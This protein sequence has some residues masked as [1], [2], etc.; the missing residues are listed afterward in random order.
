MWCT[1]PTA[2]LP[3]SLRRASFKDFNREQGV[4][5]SELYD[6]NNIAITDYESSLK[7]DARL[8]RESKGTPRT[9]NIYGYVFNI[10]TEALTLVVDDSVPAATS[11]MPS[12]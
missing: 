8:V 1:T 2:E 5:I 7:H 9:V 12:A 4:D 6:R 3:R 10:D 11:I